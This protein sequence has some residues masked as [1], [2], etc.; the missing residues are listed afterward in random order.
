MVQ[1]NSL[2]L[3]RVFLTTLMFDSACSAQKPRAAALKAI[4]QAQNLKKM[5]PKLQKYAKGE[6]QSGLDPI[7]VPIHD[8]D[9]EISGWCSVTSPA[10]FFATL[11]SRNIQDLSQS[12]DTP[13]V[14]DSVGQ[15]LHSFVQ[16]QF[17]EAILHGNADLT[18]LSLYDSIL[19][20]IHEMQFPWEKMAHPHF[21][22]LF[23]LMISLK[24]SRDYLKTSHCHQVDGTL[25]TIKQS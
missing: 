14:T 12:K 17:S 18:N 19:A 5:W 2:K 3:R 21:L 9:G 6:T 13:F 16:N 20:C 15:Q 24:A 10:K 1:D 11:L 4:Q 23:L 25:G 7:G 8:S 22:T